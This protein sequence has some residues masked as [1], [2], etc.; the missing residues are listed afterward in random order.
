VA[1]GAE[2]ALLES[3]FHAA[4]AACQAARCLPARLP[5]T[6]PA[7]KTIVLGAGKAA[8]AMAEV[9]AQTLTGELTGLV[10]TRR[11]DGIGRRARPIEIMEAAHPLPDDSS[12]QAA[13]RILELAHAAGAA[14]RVIFLISGGGSALL[15]CPAAGVTGAEKRALN[16]ALLHSGATIA[17]INLVRA[18]LSK[19]KGGR[20]AEAALPAE[21]LTFIISD[22]VGDDPALVASGPTVPAA[23]D[24]E[25]ARQILDDYGIAVP[26]TV[27]AAI[28]AAKPV[29]AAAAHPVDIIAGAADALAAVAAFLTERGWRVL[30]LGADLEGEAAAV[31]RAHGRQVLARRAKQVNGERIAMISGGELTVTVTN[32]DGRG[33]PNLEYLT[34]LMLSLDGAAGVHALACDSDGIDGSEDNA[35][36][37]LA[38]DS[39]QRAITAGL[40]PAALLAANRS[41]DI[42]HAIGGLIKTGPTQTNVNDIRI[43]LIDPAGRD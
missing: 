32:P 13:V 11:G 31:G 9:A 20:L 34:G 15:S 29:A 28:A 1:A 4:V 6:P 30:D 23:L 25:R 38:P 2:R 3:A 24:P 37:Y 35:G 12:Q 5:T 40:D 41:Y 18:H 8:A 22:V 39:Q 42:F 10:V 7:G 17:Q 36:G 27:A 33:G 26:A 21:L 43:I 16:Q 14:D 19:V